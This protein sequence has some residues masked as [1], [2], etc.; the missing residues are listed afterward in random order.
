MH[1][2]GK[3]NIE[4]IKELISVVEKSTITSFEMEESG[5]R[6]RIGKND[7]APNDRLPSGP[8]LHGSKTFLS[9]SETLSCASGDAASIADSEENNLGS[10]SLGGSLRDSGLIDVKSP[11]LGVFY[12]SS[13]SEAAPFVK[14][15]DRIKKGQVLC[16]IEAM[17]LM[18]EILAEKDGE[19]SSVC[20]ENGQIAEFGQTIFTI[21]P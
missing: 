8:D 6:I 7:F 19:I 2:G 21:K 17:K 12:A 13:S 5:Y 4:Q 18:N 20:V 14:I 9:V 1:I 15:G 10:V 11:M 3:M 16:I